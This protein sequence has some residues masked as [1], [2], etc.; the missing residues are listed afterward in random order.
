M[1]ALPI[2]STRL[3]Q[4]EWAFR[5]LHAGLDA[6][7]GIIEDRYG[8]GE[9]AHNRIVEGARRN[10][11]GRGLARR[12]IKYAQRAALEDQL[13]LGWSYAWRLSTGLD[14]TADQRTAALLGLGQ[15]AATAAHAAVTALFL[16]MGQPPKSNH[17]ALSRSVAQLV[18]ERSLL[19]F[20]WNIYLCFPTRLSSERRPRPF[21]HGVDARIFRRGQ[22]GGIRRM[23]ILAAHARLRRHDGAASSTA[24]RPRAQRRSREAVTTYD[25]AF[26]LRRHVTYKSMGTLLTGPRTSEAAHAFHKAAVQQSLAGLTALDAI[27]AQFVGVELYTDMAERFLVS[28]RR[29]V[30]GSATFGDPAAA[31]RRRLETVVS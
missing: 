21:A 14:G 8:T 20:P 30:G 10:V 2:A 23:L 26:C 15:D 7:T 29:L 27:T 28:L 9:T 6:L 16:A 3:E 31:L 5:T 18:T 22:L 17:T 1:S 13:A 25:A 12:P 19:P 24:R 11:Q 4:H